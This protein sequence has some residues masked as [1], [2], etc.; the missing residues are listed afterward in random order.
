MERKR[1]EKREKEE[2]KRDKKVPRLRIA[3]GLVLCGRCV[4]T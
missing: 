2:W 3:E 4:K 1:N